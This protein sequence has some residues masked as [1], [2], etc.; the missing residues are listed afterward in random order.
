MALATQT[1]VEQRLQIDFTNPTD[2]TVASLIAAAQGHI[3]RE[4]G[5]PVEAADYT[6]TFD[7]PYGPY[8]W[9]S[10]PPVNTITS[11]TSDGAV[12]VVAVDYYLVSATGKLGRVRDGFYRHWDSFQPQSVVV[13][14]NGG[15]TTVPLDLRDICAN[16]AARAFQSG[17]AYAALPATGVAIRSVSLDGSDSV[18][19]SD[20][21]A[22]GL[23]TIE[24]RPLQLTPEEIA[25]CRSY[26]MRD[27]A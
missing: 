6:E 17:A 2:P 1:D 15:Y 12:L 11:V 18:E 7:G 10:K 20:N 13:V 9:L 16:V 23:A 14:Y 26:R 19:Y 21:V 25:I 5:R 24:N 27:L 3:E 4:V 22:G 8:L